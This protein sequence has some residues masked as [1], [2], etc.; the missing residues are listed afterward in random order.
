LKNTDSLQRQQ[1]K[2]L[3]M[4]NSAVFG[5]EVKRAKYIRAKLNHLLFLEIQQKG[6]IPYCQN[7]SFQV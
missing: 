5:G 1:S 4:I 2:E 7:C 3:R 6:Q